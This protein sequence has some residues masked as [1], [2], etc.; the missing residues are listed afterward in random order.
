MEHIKTKDFDFYVDESGFTFNRE[1][2]TGPVKHKKSI[3]MNPLLLKHLSEE[4]QSWNYAFV[5]GIY[6]NEEEKEEYEKRDFANGITVINR[7]T[8]NGE[9]RKNS[10]HYHGV[11]EGH[12]LPYPEVY[13]ILQGKAAFI[14]QKSTN[15]DSEEELKVDDVKL[16]ILET[17]EK[18]V[19]PAW[20]AHCAI[21][22][23]DEPMAF[24]NLAAKNTPLF[25]DPITK[26]HG[27]S[28]YILKENDILIAIQNANYNN[29][30]QLKVVKPGYDEKL[31][32]IEGKSVFAQFAEDPDI[33]RYLDHPEEYEAEIENLLK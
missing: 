13:E 29:L 21:N 1:Y 20:Y 30:P 24:Y 9:C 15:F 14:L 3:E 19:V 17:G 10:G 5:S 26:K 8:M 18:L 32:I 6:H 25:Y 12:V 11:S 22:I 7:G 2:L 27:F 23:G 28:Y 16:V 33:F 4:D 31:G